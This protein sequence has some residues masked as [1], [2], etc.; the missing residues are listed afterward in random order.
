MKLDA[1]HFKVDLR[2]SPD[3]RWDELLTDPWARSK[4]RTLSRAVFR[5]MQSGLGVLSRLVALIAR[6]LAGRSQGDLDY[7]DDMEA[8][9]EWAVGDLAQVILANFSYE[10]PRVAG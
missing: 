10:L 1:R 8:W 3:V 4:A 2:K 9:S 6:H 5:R 7:L